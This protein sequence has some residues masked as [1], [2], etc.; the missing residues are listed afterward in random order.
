MSRAR[1][2][3]GPKASDPSLR[4]ALEGLIA[5]IRSDAPARAL[6]ARCALLRLCRRLAAGA[7]PVDVTRREHHARTAR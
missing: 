7:V 5:A 6:S 2:S 4:Q 3:K 1:V